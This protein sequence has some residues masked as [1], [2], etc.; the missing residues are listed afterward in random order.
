MKLSRFR[1][2]VQKCSIYT[3][4]VTNLKKCVFCQF[5]VLLIYLH[6]LLWFSCDGYLNQKFEVGFQ[7]VQNFC[8]DTQYK[9]R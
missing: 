9:L 6:Q 1:S 2:L 8:S 3:P 4:M 7:R 5:S